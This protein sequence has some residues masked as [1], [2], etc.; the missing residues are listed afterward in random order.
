MSF[1]KTTWTIRAGGVS[2]GKQRTDRLIAIGVFLY[3]FGLSYRSV[4]KF[5]PLL[6]SED[7]LK[8]IE[9]LKAEPWLPTL[10]DEMQKLVRRYINCHRG[11][12]WKANQVLQH[13]ERT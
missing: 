4:E 12:H 6:E 3:M 13:I 11:T 1:C 5:L 8:L 7:M 10:P 2:D 9:L